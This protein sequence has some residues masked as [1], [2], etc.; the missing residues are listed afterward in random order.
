MKKV[1]LITCIFACCFSLSGLC[2]VKDV[3]D[4][5]PRIAFLD[6][7]SVLKGIVNDPLLRGDTVSLFY[8][9]VTGLR[10]ESCAVDESGHFRFE[11]SVGYPM[12]VRMGF[13]SRMG[14]RVSVFLTPGEETEV[15]IENRSSKLYYQY[16]GSLARVNAEFANRNL[17]VSLFTDVL[18]IG[19]VPSVKD[20]NSFRDYLYDRYTKIVTGIQEREDLSPWTRR[21]LAMQREIELYAFLKDAPYHLARAGIFPKSVVIST[22]LPDSFFL[23]LA[24]LP[25]L[26]DSRFLYCLEYAYIADQIRGALPLFTDDFLQEGMYREGLIS[27]PDFILMS[28]LSDLSNPTSVD[29]F[30]EAQKSRLYECLKLKETYKKQCEDRFWNVIFGQDLR[31]IKE[32]WEALR[33]V[34]KIRTFSPLS[35]EEKEAMKGWSN[36]SFRR[37]V[38]AL[39]SAIS[40]KKNRGLSDAVIRADEKTGKTV[41][42]DL[43]LSLYRKHKGSPVLLVFWET[44]M[45]SEGAVM[46]TLQPLKEQLEQRGMRV[47]SVASEFSPTAEWKKMINEYTGRHVRLS[48]SQIRYLRNEYFIGN[49]PVFFLIDKEGVVLRRFTDVGLVRE[50]LK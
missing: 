23:P 37:E 22:Q 10:D 40:V 11:L 8:G 36:G 41:D 19:E 30:T 50:M 18:K 5:L 24:G 29:E 25:A 49:L 43:F 15:K 39:D 31:F 38:L 32:Y 28:R 45:A 1:F 34:D 2:E 27:E 14:E 3:L 20:V 42:E 13:A 9:T 26:G 47:V 4:P 17:R 35:A 12:E 7:P 33:E 21:L 44:G 48:R 6:K 46:K 16:T